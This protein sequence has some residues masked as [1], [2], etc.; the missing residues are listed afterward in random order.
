M[1]SSSGVPQPA[2]SIISLGM[3]I[4]LD[5]FLVDHLVPYLVR[6]QLLMG[7]SHPINMA[8]MCLGAEDINVQLSTVVVGLASYVYIYTHIYICKYICTNIYIYVQT[9]HN[10]CIYSMCLCITLK[11]LR[12]NS[13][14]FIFWKERSVDGSNLTNWHQLKRVVGKHCK[15]VA[16]PFKTGSNGETLGKRWSYIAANFHKFYIVYHIVTLVPNVVLLSRNLAWRG[17]SLTR[18]CAD[19]VCG[20]CRSHQL[21]SFTKHRLSMSCILCIYTCMY[22]IRSYII[23]KNM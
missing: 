11:S 16:W 21:Q 22:H 13:C 20:I 23:Y 10:M 15:P 5:R 12:F 1:T 3:W 19:A 14:D 6:R 17:N 8:A 9:Y 4:G 2:K 18:R 7:F